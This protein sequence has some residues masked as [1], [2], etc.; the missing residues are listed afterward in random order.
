MNHALLNWQ[1]P[2]YFL[3]NSKNEKYYL[4]LIKNQYESNSAAVIHHMV[5]A[6]LG[7]A[8]CPAWMV[9]DDLQHERLVHELPEYRLPETKYSIT[10]SKIL[11]FYRLRHVHLSIF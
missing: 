7:I 10:L 2:Q 9:D 5:L 3:Q 8:I 1:D 11:L 6:S 4:P